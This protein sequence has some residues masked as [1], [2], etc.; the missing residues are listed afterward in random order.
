MRRRLPPRH[1]SLPPRHRRLPQCHMMLTPQLR[2]HRSR[3][4]D[5]DATAATPEIAP[6]QE[7]KAVAPEHVSQ[8]ESK[9]V[10]PVPYDADATRS[11]ET[12]DIASHE[13]DKAF[14]AAVSLDADAAP[15]TA[16]APEISSFEESKADAP[17]LSD[18]ETPQAPVGEVSGVSVPS[19]TNFSEEG[20]QAIA[21]L[22]QN[23]KMGEFARNYLAKE[24]L[25]VVDEVAFKKVM[26]YFSGMRETRTFDRLVATLKAAPYVRPRPP[27]FNEAGYQMVAALK[28][29][30][31]MGQYARKFLA[32][33][34]YKVTD[35]EAFQA[36]L[37]EFS[38]RKATHHFEAFK[39]ALTRAP[40]VEK[41][42]E[43]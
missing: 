29:N 3:L 6:K 7:D 25:D 4:S 31:K 37:P 15:L 28:S 26:P 11:A 35:L 41:I 13:E 23:G 5:A 20:Y 34:G 18:L 2:R 42:A 12:P 27:S 43:E 30:G 22:K 10:V 8:D 32:K 36:M 24:G 33:N 21:K 14:G 17:A 39:N 19:T 40:F 16:A 1:A 9:P 38:G